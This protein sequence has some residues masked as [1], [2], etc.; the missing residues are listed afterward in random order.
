MYFSQTTL[1]FLFFFALSS[2]TMKPV[3]IAPVSS[4]HPAHPE[5]AAAP[6]TKFTVALSGSLP[7]VK[8]PSAEPVSDTSAHQHHH[9]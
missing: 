9:H 4:D 8:K 6:E 3:Y 5:A 2:C 7:K 1:L